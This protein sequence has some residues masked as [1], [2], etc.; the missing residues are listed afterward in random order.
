M[1]L[2]LHNLG[3]IEHAEIDV[4]PLTVL[5]GENNTN[6]TWAAY[7]LYGLAR[8]LAWPWGSPTGDDFGQD[9]LAT[10]PRTV[11]GAIDAAATKL[12][13][14]MAK[15]QEPTSFAVNRRDLIGRIKTDVAFSLSAEHLTEL[16]GLPVDSKASLRVSR[17][18]FASLEA[19]AEVRINPKLRTVR[20]SFQEIGPRQKAIAYRWRAEPGDAE[21]ALFG[22]AYDAMSSLAYRCLG[23]GTVF[24]LPSERKALVAT[25]K[26]LRREFDEVM[27]RPV[28]EFAYFLGE[29][30]NLHRRAEARELA[31]ALH[32][33]ERHI[34]GGSVEYRP[35]GAGLRL[36]YAPAGSSGVSLPMSAASSLVR[37]LAGLDVY[38]R[39]WA[40]AGDLLIIDEPEMNAHPE[41]QVALTELIAYLVNKGV[42]VLLTTHS[43]YIVDHLNNLIRA[44]DLSEADQAEI[45][46]HFRLGTS[47]CYLR[48]D[49]V[50]VYDF[51]AERADGPVKVMPV[52][53]RSDHLIG[54]KT[55]GRTTDYVSNLFGEHILP[56]QRRH[57]H[58]AE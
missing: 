57:E 38:L 55:F 19:R 56:R 16:L 4:R 26:L 47:E 49:D 28:V 2:I 6:K 41:A 58:A 45:A 34:L 13:R 1:E 27:S 36:E 23:L 11:A 33:L 9:V 14:K 46:P 8:H 52:L 18:E 22:H 32:H 42:R 50:A 51:E 21:E 10:S 5:V 12:A 29:S 15:S 35:A 20:T 43:P 30:E 24:A 48:A 54:W 37:G 25:Y 40:H 7:C 39:Y 44:G 17:G 31:G 3:R 53:D